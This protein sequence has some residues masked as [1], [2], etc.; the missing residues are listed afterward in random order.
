MGGRKQ[1]FDRSF[2]TGPHQTRFVQS[3]LLIGFLSFFRVVR[4][5]TYNHYLTPTTGRP[6]SRLLECPSDPSSVYFDLARR[7]L[8]RVRAGS[9]SSS[10]PFSPPTFSSRS[11]SFAL[12]RPDIPKVEKASRYGRWPFSLYSSLPSSLDLFSSHRRPG[13]G[14]SCTL[15]RTLGVLGERRRISTLVFSITMLIAAPHAFWASPP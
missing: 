10:W 5:P 1:P 6:C 12:M 13:Y 4:L 8:T 3:F 9:F 11:I 2:V 14:F 7:V 15:V